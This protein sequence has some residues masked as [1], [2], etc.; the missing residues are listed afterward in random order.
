M[1]T[2]NTH[3]RR[4]V[5][6][7]AAVTIAT[8]GLALAG[9]AALRSSTPPSG[10]VPM[11]N[12]STEATP[13]GLTGF[14]RSIVHHLPGDS[15]ELP[16]EGQLP[17][18]AGATGWLN[19]DPLTPEDLRGRV[20]L[21]DFWTYTCINWLRTAPYLQAWAAKYQDDG[22]TVVGVHTPEFGFEE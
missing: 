2:P 9:S 14:L 10:E 18:F 1:R 21:V 7:A 20:V 13:S 17:S 5:L 19:A 3:N 6:G 11:S 8:G 12:P 22:L 16:V 4:H 15:G